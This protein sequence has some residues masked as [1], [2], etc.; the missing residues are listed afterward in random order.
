MERR[1]PPATAEQVARAL[2]LEPHPE[3]GY[4]RETYRSPHTLTTPR[5]ERSLSTAILFLVTAGRPSR[6]HRIA[7][8]EL[9][10]HQAGAPLELLM[11]DA[12]GALR[13]HV[14]EAG[15]AAAA[16]QRGAAALFEPQ[17][18]VPAGTWQAARLL[19]SEADP[20]EWALV[21]CVVAPGFDYEDF[22]LAERDALVAEHPQERRIILELT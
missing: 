20:G 4:F 13:L 12:G 2:Q 1:T 16:P 6:F 11:I 3:G 9:W 17:L 21:S 22:E 10:I 18:V 8:D 14:L 15:G 19:G 5:G 7:S